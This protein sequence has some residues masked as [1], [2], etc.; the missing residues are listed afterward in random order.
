MLDYLF[1][2]CEV[3]QEA[4]RWTLGALEVEMVDCVEV[5]EALLFMMNI[6]LVIIYLDYLDFP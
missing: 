4:W 3:I 1:W 6:S 2:S 5:H